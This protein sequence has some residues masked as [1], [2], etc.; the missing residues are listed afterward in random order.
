M[1]ELQTGQSR[2]RLMESLLTLMETGHFESKE[3]ILLAYLDAIF[4]SYFD[5]LSKTD[6]MDLRGGLRRCFE[7][8]KQDQRLPSLLSQRGAMPLL[9][10]SFG[11]YLRRVLDTDLLP[12][13]L[14]HFQ[15]K[16]IE[17]GLLSVMTDWMADPQGRSP[18]DMADLVL[19]LINLHAGPV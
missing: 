19:D 14:S 6:D 2:R 15:G 1:R 16:F 5:E 7:Y 10:R 12:R 3:Q 17:G 4:E 11:S 8:W 18:E 9:Q 13:R